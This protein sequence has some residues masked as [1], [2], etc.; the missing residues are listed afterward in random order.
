[1]KKK[2]EKK[3]KKKK[4]YS[5][6]LTWKAVQGTKVVWIAIIVVTVAQFAITYFPPLQTVFVTESVPFGDG[7]LIVLTGATFFAVIEI[8]KQ[9][10]LRLRVISPPSA[11]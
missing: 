2:K 4:I 8:E 6:S 1:E 5:T 3:K 10:R 7:V 9:L 11:R